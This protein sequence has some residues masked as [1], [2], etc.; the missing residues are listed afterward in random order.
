[1]DQRGKLVPKLL[2]VPHNR[3]CI[4]ANVHS[5][6]LQAILGTDKDGVWKCS[7]KARF[8]HAAIA[9]DRY[10][11]W[12]ILRGGDCLH[13]AHFFLFLATGHCGAGAHALTCPLT[14]SAKLLQCQQDFVEGSTEMT[15]E[16]IIEAL[17]D[18]NLVIVSERTGIHHNSLVA[19][20]KGRVKN[21]HQK[22]LDALAAY[23][24][25]SQGVAP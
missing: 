8:A 21:P 3:K 11:Y 25:P 19:L 6:G 1:M 13:Q 9:A 24:R 10:Q 23:L 20:K 15:L 17:R 4:R 14:L 18:R 12:P 2:R 22:T 7:G 5:D 16:E